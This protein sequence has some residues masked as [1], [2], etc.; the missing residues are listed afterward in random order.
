MIFS[1]WQK[2]HRVFKR[3]AKALIILPIC[4]G[5][6]EPLLVA[7]TTLLQ[8]SCCDSYEDLSMT[9]ISPRNYLNMFYTFINFNFE[10]LTLFICNDI[11]T[12]FI[13]L[14]DMKYVLG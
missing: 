6:S 2:S 12:L 9:N 14:F 4:V 13:Y 8:I 1:Q 10:T 3:T 7:H 5:W 11:S